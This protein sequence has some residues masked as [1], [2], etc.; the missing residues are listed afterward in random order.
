MTTKRKGT[1]YIVQY[2]KKRGKEN[3]Q[4]HNI[5]KATFYDK[6][7][8]EEYAERCKRGFGETRVKAE[9]YFVVG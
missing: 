3:N 8:A 9:G 5:P 1:R 2:F 4:W 7:E 6:A